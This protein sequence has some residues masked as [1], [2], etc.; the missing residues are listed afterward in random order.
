MSTESKSHFAKRINRAPSYI[1]ELISHGR[2]V[3]DATGKRVDIEQSLAKIA[4][5]ASGSNPAVAARH[6]AARTT[7]KKPRKKREAAEVVEGS[8]ASYERLTQSVKNKHKE[9]SFD[10]VLGSRFILGD[11]R[12]EAL[13]L[14]NTL[15]ATIERLI[16]QTAPRL[17]V[18]TDKNQRLQLL[19]DEIAALK[20]VIKSEFPRSMRRLRK[21]SK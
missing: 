19:N 6:A 2:I 10:L 11:V 4:E 9:L 13:A 21:G 8:R 20:R 16:D 7:V 15:R 14:G 1:T 3:L 18:I 17:S 12:R 5:T